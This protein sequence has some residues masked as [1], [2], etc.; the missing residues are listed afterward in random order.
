MPLNKKGILYLMCYQARYIQAIGQLMSSD[1]VASA[2]IYN[3]MSSTRC[4]FLLF[5]IGNCLTT[6]KNMRNFGKLM[7]YLDFAKLS[8]LTLGFPYF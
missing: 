1:Y 5:G 8:S 6:R 7:L 3:G 2:P 4:R